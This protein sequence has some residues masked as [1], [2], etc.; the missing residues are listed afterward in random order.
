[1]IP[2][3]EDRPMEL[4]REALAEISDYRMRFYGANLTELSALVISNA[5]RRYHI[6]ETSKQLAKMKAL[7]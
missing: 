1:M 4:A 6:E 3:P 5:I 7:L 2:P